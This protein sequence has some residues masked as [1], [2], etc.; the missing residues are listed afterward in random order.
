MS[1]DT[2]DFPR[3]SWSLIFCD[4]TRCQTVRKQLFRRCLWHFV[5]IEGIGWR[6]FICSSAKRQTR[7]HIP[8][9]HRLPE[10]F[11]CQ[12]MANTDVQIIPHSTD[13]LRIYLLHVRV[14]CPREGH[15]SRPCPIEVGTATHSSIHFIFNVDVIQS[16]GGRELRLFPHL[17]DREYG[18]CRISVSLTFYTCRYAFPPR[19]QSCQAELRQRANYRGCVFA[20][21][22]DYSLRAFTTAAIRVS[23][24]RRPL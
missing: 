16:A 7:S 13:A 21:M 23:H 15:P 9:H 2:C 4:R 19:V 14:A 6:Y 18:W 1:V 20:F 17:H 3:C 24:P 10:C 12:V 5:L 22:G 11:P 8:H